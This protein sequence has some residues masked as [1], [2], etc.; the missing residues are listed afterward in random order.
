MHDTA[1]TQPQ[2]LE[3]ILAGIQ[4]ERSLLE[5][6]NRLAHAAPDQNHRNAIFYALESKKN[7][8]R[9]FTELY[10]TLTGK[11][12]EYERRHVEF[13]SYEE[14]LQ[15]A[16]QIEEEGCQFYQ[17]NYYR[18]YHPY[19]QQAL[20]QAAY[21]KRASAERLGWLKKRI[22]IELR[23]YG[24]KP[25]VVNIDEAS[26]QNKTY[27]TALW[28]GDKLQV[29][30]MSI[31]VGEDIGLEVHPTTDQFLRIEEGQGLVQ[32]GD[33]P[34]NLDYQVQAYDDFAIMIPA[35]KWHNLTNT[36]RKPIK[37]YAIYAPPEHPFGTVHE[38]KAIAIAAE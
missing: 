6:Y 3:F 13:Q 10:T 22:P 27:R 19:V 4:R 2:G 29:T 18:C 15:K 24:G 25:F 9:Y 26:K 12:P 34:N 7:H 37:L 5:C 36:G 16:Y 38:T 8:L 31:G 33:S 14:G 23:D 30:L 1:N 32:M 20:L 28:T 21:Q 35:G 11:Q 17:S